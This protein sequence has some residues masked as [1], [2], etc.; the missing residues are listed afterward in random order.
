MDSKVSSGGVHLVCGQRR[1]HCSFVG[2]FVAMIVGRAH[3]QPAPYGRF[4]TLRVLPVIVFKIRALLF[5][6]HKEAPG[7]EPPILTRG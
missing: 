6:V 3:R 2:S 5:G 7:L 1:V 4:S